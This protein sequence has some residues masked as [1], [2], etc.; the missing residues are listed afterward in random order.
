M[1]KHEGA[2]ADSEQLIS[3]QLL[4]SLFPQGQMTLAWLMTSS[5][6]R[7]AWL[8]A[9]EA[10]PGYR[11]MREL[12]HYWLVR[13]LRAAKKENSSEAFRDLLEGWLIRLGVEA[14]EGVF[15]PPRR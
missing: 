12:R 7:D 9:K 10:L 8:K 3:V 6:T 11:L 15:L 4:E 1:A 14:P 13:L 5:P 2:L